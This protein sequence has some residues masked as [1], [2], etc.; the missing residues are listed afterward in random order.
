MQ[1]ASAASGWGYNGSSTCQLTATNREA[2]LPDPTSAHTFAVTQCLCFHTNCHGP[3][4]MPALSMLPSVPCLL[5]ACNANHLH[6]PTRAGQAVKPERCWL[7]DHQ[8]PTASQWSGQH[9]P[10][11]WL[12]RTWGVSG[13]ALL[14]AQGCKGLGRGIPNLGFCWGGTHSRAQHR[15]RLFKLVCV[16]L[17]AAK[18]SVG[19]FFHALT[20]AS[21]VP[22]MY[23]SSP[24]SLSA[25]H[26]LHCVLCSTVFVLYAACCAA[27]CVLCCMLRAACCV[28]CWQV[29]VPEGLC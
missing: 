11:V 17:Q 14:G 22:H 15:G 12:G 1:Q 27:C 21:E 19:R 7:P 8:Q 23:S 24:L 2:Q 4:H 16:S 26:V 3:R 13:D 29:C 28:L 5:R 6:P 18:Q 20:A 25:A 10:R 9:R